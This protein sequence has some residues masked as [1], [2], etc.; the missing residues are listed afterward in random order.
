MNKLI[1]H[2]NINMY[3]IFTVFTLNYFIE[4]IV[5]QIKFLIIVCNKNIFQ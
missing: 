2:I 3:Y 4:Y 5:L 1:L